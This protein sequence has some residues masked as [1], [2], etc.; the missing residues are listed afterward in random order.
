M[1]NNRRNIRQSAHR[2]DVILSPVRRYHMMNSRQN[3]RQSVHLKDV[4]LSP[5]AKD[6][7]WRWELPA[8]VIGFSS[9]SLPLS[10][11]N[12]ND[13]SAC[14]GFTAI[15]ERWMR[16]TTMQGKPC[17]STGGA[18]FRACGKTIWR[19]EDVS[20]HEFTRAVSRWEIILPRCRRQARSEAERTE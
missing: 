5:V 10:A 11:G 1:M 14:S 13:D 3:I 15:S 18:A 2:K 4:I 7:R 12:R 19:R 16:Y 17:T 20:G 9:K 8:A 6:L